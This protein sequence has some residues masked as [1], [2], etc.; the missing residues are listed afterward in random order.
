MA[1]SYTP[2][3]LYCYIIALKTANLIIFWAVVIPAALQ[4]FTGAPEIIFYTHILIFLFSIKFLISKQINLKNLFLRF[5]GYYF[6]FFCLTI[7]QILPLLEFLPYS[8]RGKSFEYST[9]L[10]F[11]FKNLITMLLP[12]FYGSHT[13]GNFWGAQNYF[14]LYAY[15][16]ILP[17]FLLIFVNKIFNVGDK[18]LK[19]EILFCGF[20]VLLGLFLALGKYSPFYRYIINII[21][22][23]S[24]LRAP[25]RALFISLFGWTLLTANILQTII[26]SSDFKQFRKHLIIIFVFSLIILILYYIPPNTV[27]SLITKFFDIPNIAL[28]YQTFHFKLKHLAVVL[29]LYSNFFLDWRDFNKKT[30]LLLILSVVFYET[31]IFNT[32]YIDYRGTNIDFSNNALIKELKKD[33][34]YFRLLSFEHLIEMP[35]YNINNISTAISYTP[36]QLKTI[37]DYLA[38]GVDNRK[39]YITESYKSW[40]GIQKIDNYNSP[41]LDLLNVKYYYNYNISDNDKFTKIADNLYKKNTFVERFRF[42]YDWRCEDNLHNSLE[43]LKNQQIDYFNTVIVNNAEISPLQRYGTQNTIKSIKYNFNSIILNVEINTDAVL[44]TSEIYY[45]GWQVKLDGK[46]AFLLK[47]NNIFRGVYCYKGAQTIEFYYRPYYIRY[48][49]LGLIIFIVCGLIFVLN[50]YSKKY[51]N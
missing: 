26:D 22:P 15:V 45:P 41:L 10:S 35:K 18:Q 17:I 21:V 5:S 25:S 2:L 49:F 4:F 11:P 32:Y 40:F 48:G 3:I 19:I 33:N 30:M 51:E 38:I 37:C 16:G 29:V 8:I 9:F 47:L 14:E 6:L 27:V 43:L 50:I 7:I 12:Y 39:N 20:L 13:D 1:F 34:E 23:F 28:K 42:Y 44:F 24:K 36:T 31:F 46:G